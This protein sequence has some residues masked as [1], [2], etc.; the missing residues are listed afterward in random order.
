[1]TKKKTII[2]VNG[3]ARSGKDTF[4]DI[5]YNKYQNRRFQV[6][7]ISSVDQIKECAKIL[8]WDG[9]SKTLIDR[10]FLS[11]LKDLATEYCDSPFKYEL[12][13][14]KEFYNLDKPGVLFIH[15]REPEE[16]AKLKQKYP[17]IRTVLV[18]NPNVPV[19]NNNTGD[20][21][22]ENYV[23][24]YYI[25]ND[26]TLEQYKVRVLELMEVLFNE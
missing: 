3:M 15:I 1:M 20:A 8:G 11:D 16:I 26:G 10:K 17:D 5:V 12:K 7:K 9:I 6:L 4:C 14:I 21:S 22:V 18:R 23:Y 25:D 2:I 13:R 19:I 24:D